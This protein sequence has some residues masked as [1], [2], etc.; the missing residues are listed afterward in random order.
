M[1]HK[2]LVTGADGFIGSH[3]VEHLVA[4]GH[5]V[6]AFVLYNS[7]GS[8]GWLDTIAAGA[9][10]DVEVF[11]G[12]VRDPGRVK[13]AVAGCDRV[14][15]LAALIS[16]PYSYLAPRSFT[17]TNVGG[18]EN[19]L[20]AARDAGVAKVVIAST[21]EVYGTAQAVPIAETHP[22]NAQSP[23]AASKVAADQL[24]LSFHRSFGLPLTIV[25]PFN[26]YG[27]RQSTRAVLPTIITQLARGER[28]LKLGATHPTRDFSY[29]DDTA[30]GFAAAADPARAVGEVV[31]LGSDFEVSVG[32]AARLIGE[33][34]GVSP[35]FAVERERLRPEASEVER[36]WAD[37]RKAAALLGWRPAFGGREG[38]KRG[39]A[40]TID[41]FRNPENLKLFRPERYQL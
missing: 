22:L 24:A 19:V 12:D 26:T 28:R 6:R 32:E 15:H 27:P 41:W 31:N 4:S 36:L 25:R 30:A 23:Y 34:M 17:D 16:I 9:L 20:V 38:F 1:P 33:I 39:L 37:N 7:F 11:P 3:L 13:T 35:E 21:S 29:V 14:L 40:R 2:I 8:A 18:T 5:A 10:A